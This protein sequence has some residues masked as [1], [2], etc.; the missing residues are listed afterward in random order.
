MFHSLTIFLA[1]SRRCRSPGAVIPHA[2]SPD[3]T[4]SCTSYRTLVCRL[5]AEPRCTVTLFWVTTSALFKAALKTE[6]IIVR[7]Q[8]SS[9]DWAIRRLS[10]GFSLP[11]VTHTLWNWTFTQTRVPTQD[12]IA[13]A[14]G[15]VSTTMGFPVSIME[16][17]VRRSTRG[18][19]QLHVHLDTKTMANVTTLHGSRSSTL[20]TVR[21]KVQPH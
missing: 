12:L 2:L 18:L 7:M 20:S 8:S 17:G 14:R 5:K 13:A 3:S 4:S 21:S 11:L 16:T 19:P 1:L 15:F 6:D 9:S 10:P